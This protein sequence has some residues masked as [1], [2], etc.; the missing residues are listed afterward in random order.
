MGILNIFKKKNKIDIS[1]ATAVF[2]R[3]KI[4]IENELITKV[5]HS[6]DNSFDFADKYSSNSNEN[7]MLVSLKQ[8]LEKDPSVRIAINIPT[9]YCAFRETIN[10]KWIIEPY[11]EGNDE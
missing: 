9:G 1:P 7:I 5:Y 6:I 3:K 11:D 2:T 8:I 10:D 4:M